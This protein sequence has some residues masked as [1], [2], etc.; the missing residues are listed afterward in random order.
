MN[1][2]KVLRKICKNCGKPRV[3]HYMGLVSYSYNLCPGP[4]SRIGFGDYYNSPG[5]TFKEEEKDEKE[6]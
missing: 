6:A 3:Q 2:K 5:T 4:D 1:T